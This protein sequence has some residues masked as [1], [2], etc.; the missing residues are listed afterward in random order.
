MV[1]SIVYSCS[2]RGQWLPVGIYN[3]GNT[4]SMSATLQ[5]LIHCKPLH[6]LFLRDLAHPYQ[7]CSVLRSGKSSCLTC[8]MDKTILE[9]FGS[10]VGIDTIAALEEHSDFST[11][12]TTTLLEIVQ[13]NDTRGLPLIPSRLLAECWR[14]RSM[15][16]VAGH[17]QH[18]AQ[19]FFD[20]FVD[21]LA[22][23]ALAYQKSAQEMR[24]MV[25]ESRLLS[26]Y[27]SPRS[28][29]GN[30]LFG[31]IRFF[32]R[33]C[34]SLTHVA[35][36]S[37][38]TPSDLTDFIKNIFTGT[39]TSV[40]VCQQCGCK[41]TQSESFSNVSLPLA[42]EFLSSTSQSITR[43]GK[44]SVDICLDHFTLPETLSDP[45]FCVVCNEK[46]ITQKQHTFSKLPEVLCLHL[47]RFNAAAN[48]K[49]TDFVSFPARDLDMGK[50]LTHW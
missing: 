30:Y 24:N 31:L 49:I 4:C 45:V 32:T 25:Y 6:D 17:G 41:R 15:K 14:N 47:K 42:K 20:A 27:E 48:K 13:P 37:L 18:D 39:L 19:E 26:K 1:I 38:S 35:A 28:D 7:S 22:H 10:A 16:N 36:S 50:H 5:C 44:I 2:A 23:H 8:E 12:T 43:Q 29:T 40:L 21:C 9:Y 46:T 33:A 11:G 3:L 34:M